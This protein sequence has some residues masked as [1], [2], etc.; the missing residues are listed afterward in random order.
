[1]SRV[2]DFNPSYIQSSG[3][4]GGSN[5]P[6]YEWA[7][8]HLL[9]LKEKD[10]GGGGFRKSNSFS[11]WVTHCGCPGQAKWPAATSGDLR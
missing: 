9:A 7:L 11:V 5:P 4:G 2:V 8:V 1:M 6:P 3:T 10:V